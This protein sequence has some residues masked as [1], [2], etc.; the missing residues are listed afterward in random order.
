MSY[1]I[2]IEKGFDTKNKEREE[3]RFFP[4]IYPCTYTYKYLK[5]AQEKIIEIHGILAN[6][7]K[8]FC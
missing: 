6:V 5:H 2:V 4:T 7:A 3:K 8:D 1:L